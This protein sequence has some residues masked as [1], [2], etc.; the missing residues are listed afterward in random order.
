MHHSV[1]FDS[2]LLLLTKVFFTAK[3]FEAC[4]ARIRKLKSCFSDLQIT[5]C[6]T[7]NHKFIELTDALTTTFG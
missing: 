4:F 5:K 3:G 7:I 6:Q 2:M 1:T